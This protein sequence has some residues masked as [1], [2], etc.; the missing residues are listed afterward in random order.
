[1]RFLLRRLGF[2]L[3]ALFVAITVNFFIPRLMPG[4]V[5][6]NLMSKYPN[7]KPSAQRALDVLLGVGHQGSLLH[8]YVLYLGQLA[9]GN[10]GIDPLQFPTPVIDIIR[11][12]LPWTIVLV[13]TAT[14]I[15]W[16]LGTG[17]GILAA[18]RRGGRLDQLLPALSF[19]QATPYFFLA[20][21]LVWLLALH[22]HLFPAQQGF[23]NGLTIGFNWAFISSAVVHSILPALTIVLTSAAG[24]ML[25]MRNVMVATMGE[26]Y[27]LAAQ[28]KGLSK[29]RVI[30]TYGARNAI[31][32]SISGFALALG[33]VVSGTL[34]MEIVF[35]YPGIG[36]QLYNAVTSDDYPLTQAIF[37]IISVAVL[38]ANIGADVIYVILD[39]R[40]RRRG[41]G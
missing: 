33:F 4:N 20:L 25:Q 15:S 21:V 9:H 24:W 36:T 8:Q 16:L 28:A 39:P 1:M 26:D 5:V 22:F 19:L 41:V 12:A 13:G 7:L 18:W 31:L 29:R 40:V 2:Y 34:L 6:E 38:L 3:I 30:F 10:F 32:P 35:N 11:A 27:V 14:V 23:S 17:L 37:L